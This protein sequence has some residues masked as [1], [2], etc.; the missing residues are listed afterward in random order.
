MQNTRR[1]AHV[2][3]WQALGVAASSAACQWLCYPPAT[4]TAAHHVGVHGVAA[5]QR[6]LHPAR[7]GAAAHKRRHLLCPP[8][9]A[10]LA[11]QAHADGADQGGLARACSRVWQG[12]GRWMLADWGRAV[13]QARRR[14][15]PGGGVLGPRTVGAKHQVELGAGLYSGLLVGLRSM[16]GGQGLRRG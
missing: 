7:V 9:Q 3:S 2:L 10:G 11:R 13:Q 8:Q 12:A 14:C 6:D 16:G 1:P 5:A 15:I 4:P